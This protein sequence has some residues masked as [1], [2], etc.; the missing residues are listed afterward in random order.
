ME[1]LSVNKEKLKNDRVPCM[2]TYHPRL[3]QLSNILH[4]H[5]QLLSSNKRLPEVF[6]AAP[7][8]TNAST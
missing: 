3:K 5:F 8:K 6:K 7:V 1:D 4:K 2:M